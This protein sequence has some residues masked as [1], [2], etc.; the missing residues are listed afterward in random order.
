MNT[1]PVF[2]PSSG[3]MPVT[4]NAPETGSTSRVTASINSTV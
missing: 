2:N 3:N 1:D 4:V